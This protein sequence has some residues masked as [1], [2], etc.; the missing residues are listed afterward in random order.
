MLK[1]MRGSIMISGSDD[2]MTRMAANFVNQASFVYQGKEERL[3]VEP[4]KDCPSVYAPLP[5]CPSAVGF[6]SS[7]RNA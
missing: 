7:N 1:I 4:D 2:Q 5:P 6:A 3:L